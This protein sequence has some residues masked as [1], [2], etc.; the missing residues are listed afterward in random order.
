MLSFRSRGGASIWSL[1]L[2]WVIAACS[3][4][5]CAGPITY[6]SVTCSAAGK[7]VTAASSCDVSVPLPPPH[8]NMVA[9]A[10]ASAGAYGI[11]FTT[12]EAEDETTRY[13]AYVSALT[14]TYEAVLPAGPVRPGFVRIRGNVLGYAVDTFWRAYVQ[15]GSS[16][17]QG[18]GYLPAS[19]FKEGGTAD[20]L[21]ITLGIPVPIHTHV[22]A[23]GVANATFD[24]ASA[25]LTV[26][27]NYTFLEA[28]GV[29]PVSYSAAEIPEPAF[30]LPVFGVL[31]MA[32]IRRRYRHTR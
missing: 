9:E 19:M 4:V 7:S 24:R 5:M 13:I 27:F 3:A 8:E 26:E 6:S 23:T 16:L 15:F 1:R 18:G 30:T 21:P 29:T 12:K 10:K 32:G 20:P 28:D 17:F 25:S 22:D 31:L 11:A 2:C 14:D